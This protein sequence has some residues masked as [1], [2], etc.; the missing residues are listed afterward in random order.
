MNWRWLGLYLGAGFV[1][2]FAEDW[3]SILLSMLVIVIASFRLGIR[4]K[5]SE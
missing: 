2:V 1:F 5:V 3:P 4:K